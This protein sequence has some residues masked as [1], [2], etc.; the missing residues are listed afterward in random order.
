MQISAFLDPST[1]FFLTC[2]D[3]KEAEVIISNEAPIHY[4][5]LSSSS[6]RQSSTTTSSNQNEQDNQ[7]ITLKNLFQTCGVP[8]QSTTPGFKPSTIKEEISQYIATINERLIFSTYWNN[9]KERLPILSSIARQYNVMCATSIDCESAFSI[10]GH[11]HRK[12]RSSLAPSTLR[13]TMLLR[14][15]YKNSKA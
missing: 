3:K 13:Y 7:L 15:Y 14:E 4:A 12:N 10:A 9:N 8:V 6:S 5:K 1:Y 2:D 11:I